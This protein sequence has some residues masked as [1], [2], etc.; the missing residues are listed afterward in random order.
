MAVAE[1]FEP[2]QSPAANPSAD[3]MEESWKKTAELHKAMVCR[4]WGYDV[5]LR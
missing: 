3:T 4:K 5:H 2:T 1:R